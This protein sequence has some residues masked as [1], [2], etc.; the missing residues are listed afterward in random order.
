LV[1]IEYSPTDRFSR[2]KY[3]RFNWLEGVASTG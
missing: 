1:L 3:C 2:R